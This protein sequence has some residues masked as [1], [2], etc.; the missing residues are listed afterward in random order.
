M[1]AVLDV[2]IKIALS[3]IEDAYGQTALHVAVSRKS[4]EIVLRLIATGAD[5]N[6]KD[7][8]EKTALHLTV[9]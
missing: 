1:S 6:A 5:I 4:E 3:N 8:K 7:N 2:D 9:F